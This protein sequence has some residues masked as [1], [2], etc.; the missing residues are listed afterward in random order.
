MLVLFCII[1]LPPG[2]PL[3]RR[4]SPVGDDSWR[5]LAEG[6]P[7]SSCSASSYPALMPGMVLA[8]GE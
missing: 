2:T 5:G 7:L 4:V 6:L 8:L 1:C 3:T